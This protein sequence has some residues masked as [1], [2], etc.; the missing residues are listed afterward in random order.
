MAGKEE[1]KKKLKSEKYD[2]STGVLK[3]KGKFCPKCGPGVFLAEHK[4][5]YSCGKCG[6]ME[7]RK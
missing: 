5:R 7:K 4:D 6:Y 1:R 3:R 2:I